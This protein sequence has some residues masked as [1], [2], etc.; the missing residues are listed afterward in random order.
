LVCD[1][2]IQHEGTSS[3]SPASGQR[4]QELKQSGFF[5]WKRTLMESD[6]TDMRTP[7]MQGR[8]MFDDAPD[9]PHDRLS[10]WFYW[11]KQPES[12]TYMDR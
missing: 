7:E 5:S 11:K 9:V 4:K 1:V 10:A 12:W 8:Q 3:Q 2:P 6:N